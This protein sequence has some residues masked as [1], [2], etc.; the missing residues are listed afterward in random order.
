[1]MRSQIRQ[2]H[3]GLDAFRD[4]GQAKTAGQRD[5]GAHDGGV[6]LVA[7][8]IAYERAV[9]LQAMDGK[10]LQITELGIH[11]AEI[12]HRDAKPQPLQF[13]QTRRES[14]EKRWESKA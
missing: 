9:D 12:V 7:W 10:A 3:L 14:R 2:L 13:G 5:D 4:D 1:M 11:G 6:I 8:N